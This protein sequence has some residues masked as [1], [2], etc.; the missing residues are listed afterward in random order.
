MW[1]WTSWYVGGFV[2]G[3]WGFD[4]H[5]SHPCSATVLDGCWLTPVGGEVV[6]Y[7]M[8]PSFI[9]GVTAGYNYQIPGSAIVFG[10]ETEFAALSLKGSS[11]FAGVS[12]AL[13]AASLIANATVGHWYNATT[14]R[15][16]WT[17]DRVYFYGKGG[18][19]ISTVELTVESP[20]IDVR[21][22]SAPEPASGIFWVGPGARAWNMRLPRSGA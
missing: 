20:A 14:L 15:L 2:G 4:A 8:S 7:S 16:G 1:S 21:V 5:T 19:T 22:R 3:A 17:W 18:A 13:G 10:F 11:S 6:H 12:N 9:G